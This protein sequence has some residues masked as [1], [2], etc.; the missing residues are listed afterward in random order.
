M[1][2]TIIRVAAGCL[3]SSA[4]MLGVLQFVQA[5]TLI[6]VIVGMAASGLVYLPFIGKELKVLVRL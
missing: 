6:L 4:I 3:A 5:P 2:D 1:H